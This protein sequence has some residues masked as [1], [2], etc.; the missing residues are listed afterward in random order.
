MFDELFKVIKVAPGGWSWEI[1]VTG[2][3]L[4]CAFYCE[5]MGWQYKVGKYWYQLDFV[6]IGQTVYM[7]RYIKREVA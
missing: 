3:R 6:P 7:G 5:Q 2:K 4:D 1:G